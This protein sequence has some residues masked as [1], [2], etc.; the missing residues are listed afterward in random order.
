MTVLRLNADLFK[1]YKDELK[2]LSFCETSETFQNPEK[3][4]CINKKTATYCVQS[5]GLPYTGQKISGESVVIGKTSKSSNKDKSFLSCASTI[6][7]GDATIDKVITTTTKCGA[8]S[9]KVRTRSAR[10]CEVGDKLSSRNGQKSCVAKLVPHEDLPFTA[11]GMVPDIIFSPFA[12]PS[13]M[14]MGSFFEG[15]FGKLSCFEGTLHDGTSFSQTMTIEEMQ[16]LLHSKKFA[17]DGCE[18]MYSGATGKPVGRVFLG[19]IYYMRLKHLVSE[20]VHVRSTGPKSMTFAS[21][22]EGRSKEGG[23]RVGHMESDSIISHGCSSVL[24]DRLLLNSDG[25]TS[26]IC[27]NCGILSTPVGQATISYCQTCQSSSSMTK[28]LVPCALRVLQQELLT[29][30]IHMKLNV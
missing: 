2:D 19:S 13:R 11:D 23:L 26:D 6:T 15:V 10:P 24:M 28:V 25:I 5:D 7:K 27:K 14:T 20:K 9:V 16:D 8:Q 12:L 22:T 29:A 21:P 18:M 3:V 4:K 30:N 17:K 1:T